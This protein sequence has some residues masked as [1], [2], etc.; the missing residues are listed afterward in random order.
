MCSNSLGRHI[1]RC[2]RGKRATAKA[3]NGRIKDPQA[4]AER[5]ID[6]VYGTTTGVVEMPG[7]PPDGHHVAHS[8]Q[9]PRDAVRSAGANGVAQADFVAPHC[10][11]P[12]RDLGNLLR[13]CGTVIGARDY[14][15]YIAA[16]RQIDVSRSFKNRREAVKAF[17]NACVDVGLG[18]PLGCRA[19]NS[20]LIGSGFQSVLIPAHVRRKCSVT[21]SG[22]AGNT[23]QNFGG[24]RHLRHR[25]GRYKACNFDPS[26][27]RVAQS[28]D[29]RDFVRHRY[30]AGF[31]L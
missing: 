27:S 7:K 14:A 12:V 24:I 2:A 6:I 13:R 16:H 18:K 9:H 25:L 26:K 11:K 8:K 3:A 1:A 21:R 29:E 22:P 30:I 20:D 15:R 4:K 5:R 19:E 23:S 28:I 31:V 10:K 17:V